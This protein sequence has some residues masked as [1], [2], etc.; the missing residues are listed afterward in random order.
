[1]LAGQT[2]LLEGSE[3]KRAS[4]MN[5][6]LFGATG[7]TGRIV[8]ARSLRAG[9]TVT[10]L[11]RDPAKLE[12]ESPDLQVLCGSVQDEA[13][14]LQA[15]TGSA[16]VISVLGPAQNGPAYEVSA[17]TANIIRA[18]ERAGV[19]RLII[20][21]GAGV[22]DP[23]DAPGPLNR[24][25]GAWVMLVAGHVYEDMR[26]SVDE[27][28]RSDL[29]WTIVRVPTLTNAPATGI[30][31]GYVGKGTG[32]RLSRTSLAEFLLKQLH[33]RTLLRQAPVISN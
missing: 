8:L 22:G 4:I 32:A 24:F 21:T 29:D 33:D 18:M 5:I 10:V 3:A 17:A 31:L 30:R 26:G 11:V 23:N 14:V 13:Q 12:L 20:T 25:M 15:V 2:A 9:Y 19:R 6:T 7:R 27:V 1:M 16:A 28:R